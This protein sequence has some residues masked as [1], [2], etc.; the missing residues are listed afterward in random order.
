MID[1]RVK[2]HLQRSLQEGLSLLNINTTTSQQNQLCEFLILLEKW[3]KVHNLTSVR[4]IMDM[5][6]KHLLDSLSIARF[7]VGCRILDVGSGA[8][9][10]G[11]P[12][13]IICPDKKF[14][15]LDSNKKKTSFLIFVVTSLKLPNVKV[16]NSRV[17]QYQDESGFDVIISRAFA[18]LGKFVSCSGHLCRQ[19]GGFL[20]MKGKIAQVKKELLPEGYLLTKIETVEVPGLKGERCVIFV[21]KKVN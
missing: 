20:A 21:N 17:E 11:S 18:D 9:F 7:L 4:N 3:N 16:V 2:Q 8:G 5:V 6:S 15:L 19:Q 10:P 12:L 13:S 1:E 14:V